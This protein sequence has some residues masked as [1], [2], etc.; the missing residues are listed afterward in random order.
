MPSVLNGWYQYIKHSNVIVSHSNKRAAKCVSFI[1]TQSIQGFDGF[2]DWSSECLHYQKTLLW[3]VI[4]ES[5]V[6][7][8]PLSNENSYVYRG[9]G[10]GVAGSLIGMSSFSGNWLVTTAEELEGAIGILYTEHR[11]CVRNKR[12]SVLLQTF[13]CSWNFVDGAH[14]LPVLHACWGMVP[15]FISNSLH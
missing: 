1:L 3:Q 12:H 11:N 13:N 8:S 7:L 10:R 15:I 5:V 9:K 6:C 4:F 2:A 14:G